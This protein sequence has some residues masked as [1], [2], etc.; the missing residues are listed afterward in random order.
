MII[1]QGFGTLP[2]VSPV[3]FYENLEVGVEVDSP[4][5][6]IELR[7]LQEIEVSIETDPIEV[8]IEVE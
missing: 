2:E 1:T 5:L 7:G 8:E 6:N 4:E 3:V